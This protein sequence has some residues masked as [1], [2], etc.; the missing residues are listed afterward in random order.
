MRASRSRSARDSA[1]GGSARGML[2]LSSA[3]ERHDRR[4]VPLHARARHTPEISAD[5]S[6]EACAAPAARL[7]FVSRWEAKE[8]R[9]STPSRRAETTKVRCSAAYQNT[10][11]FEILGSS[12]NTRSRWIEEMATID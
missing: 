7:F 5:Y 9:S 8:S 11:S 4:L 12:M 1:P 10:L 3:D 2:K 6:A